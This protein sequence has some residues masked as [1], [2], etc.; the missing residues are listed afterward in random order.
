MRSGIGRF[1]LVGVLVVACG[2]EVTTV[3]QPTCAK[4]E[5]GEIC[6][7]PRRGADEGSGSSDDGADDDVA[8]GDGSSDGTSDGKDEGDADGAPGGAAGS[9]SDG[10][11]EEPCLTFRGV[12][13]DFRRGDRA[14]GHVD[15]ETFA[16]EGET[17][18]LSKDL[19]SDGK[20]RLAKENPDSITSAKSFAFWYRDDPEDNV[21]FNVTMELEVGPDGG[22]VFGSEEFFPLDDL[23]FGNQ[24]EDH[25]F[26]FTTEMHAQLYYDGVQDGTFTFEGD[27]DLW[28]F[29]DGTLVID[30]GG[31]HGAL[32]GSFD[33]S[34]VA[35]KLGLEPGGTYAF[36]LFHAERHSNESSFRL[37]STLSFVDCEAD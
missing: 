37:T 9:S 35:E 16:G 22:A 13:R 19:A 23:G 36:D 25:N 5:E 2:P 3:D 20:P 15:F 18:L 28:V 14:G 21:A 8:D 30:L 24:G 34:E 12:L 27:D 29:V 10:G 33:L 32:I 4:L 11:E 31:T 6:L 7:F 17:G 1:G 26:G